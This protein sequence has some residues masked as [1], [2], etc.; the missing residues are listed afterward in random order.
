MHKLISFQW[1]ILWYV[2]TSAIVCVTLIPAVSFHNSILVAIFSTDWTH[3]LAYAF[4]ATL[5]MLAWERRTGIAI[6]FG[7]A[8]LSVGLQALR[9]LISGGPIDLDGTVVN[10]LGI[11]AGILLSLNILTLRSHVRR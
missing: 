7:L 11:T 2:L 1:R 8:M 9:G 5:P 6:C 3:F 10:L 4:V